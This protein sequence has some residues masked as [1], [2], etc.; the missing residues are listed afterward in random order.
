MANTATELRGREVGVR[1]VNN[2]NEYWAVERWRVAMEGGGGADPRSAMGATNLPVLGESLEFTY[3][4]GGTINETVVVYC[5]NIRVRMIGKTDCE[6]ICTFGAWATTTFFDALRYSSS[7]STRELML[8]VNP[9][10][11]R[12]LYPIEN[13]K[14]VGTRIIMPIQVITLSTT[15]VISTGVNASLAYLRKVNDGLWGGHPKGHFLFMGAYAD[16][17]GINIWNVHYEFHYHPYGWNWEVTAKPL[18]DKHTG[19][20]IIGSQGEWMLEDGEPPYE[21]ADFSALLLF[22]G[23]F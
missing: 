7:T 20:Q 21:E 17:T 18:V 3:S 23:A 4:P 14:A 5:N 13:G 11:R 2:R 19:K 10:T 16:P 22:A 12:M 9:H 6:A 1:I 15:K 8:Y